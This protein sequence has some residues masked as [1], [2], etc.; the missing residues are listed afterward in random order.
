MATKHHL[1]CARTA[2]RHFS[3]ALVYDSGNMQQDLRVRAMYMHSLDRAGRNKI[4]S[5]CIRGGSSPGLTVFLHRENEGLY[6]TER[7]RGNNGAPGVLHL[8]LTAYAFAK[9]CKLPPTENSIL[10]AGIA[11]P[12]IT[13]GIAV[14]ILCL[15]CD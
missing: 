9:P 4:E 14:W 11:L 15:K 6:T 7:E 12:R 2:T 10:L 8:F 3:K 1:I 13:M 5:V